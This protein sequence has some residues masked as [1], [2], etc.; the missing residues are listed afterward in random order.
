MKSRDPPLPPWLKNIQPLKIFHES[1]PPKC[2]NNGH[3]SIDI[4]RVDPNP[5]FRLYEFWIE[6]LAGIL[7]H[8]ILISHIITAKIIL[9]R[10]NM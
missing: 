7:V 10:I 6:I 1:E 3:I 5:D 2:A 4:T 8:L 9:D